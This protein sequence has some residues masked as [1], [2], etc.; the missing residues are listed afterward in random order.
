[1]MLIRI[2]GRVLSV[3]FVGMSAPCGHRPTVQSAQFRDGQFHNVAP[4]KRPSGWRLLKLW[5]QFMFKDTSRTVPTEALSVT[6]LTP[7]QLQQSPDGS[8]WRLGHSTVLMKLNGQFWITDPVF[9]ERA[10][11]VQW[12]G[13]KRFIPTPISLEQL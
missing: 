9:S 11:P 7:D 12:A 6:P 4:P 5:W 3:E 10:S 13:P 2:P 1:M 8:I